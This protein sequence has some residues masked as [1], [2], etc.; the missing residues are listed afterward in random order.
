MHFVFYL[1]DARIDVFQLQGKKNIGHETFDWSKIESYVQK[2]PKNALISLV[3]D[4]VDEDLQVEFMPSLLPWEKVRLQQRLAEKWQQKGALN[5]RFIWTGEKQQNDDGRHEELLLTSVLHP[6]KPL[7]KLLKQLTDRNALLIGVHSAAFMLKSVLEKK[8]VSQLNLSKKQRKTPIMLIVRMTPH[9]YRQCF[10]YHGQLRLSR[11]VELESKDYSEQEIIELLA[12]ESKLATRFIYNQKVLPLGVP[13]N[14][15]LIDHLN[16][17]MIRSYWQEFEQ[18][19]NVISPQWNPEQNFFEVI[20][21]K[22]YPLTTRRKTFFGSDLLAHEL[23][24]GLTPSFFK[25]DHITK[26]NSLRTLATV[27]KIGALSVLVFI[28]FSLVSASLQSNY[29]QKRSE[30]YQQR[31]TYLNAEQDFLLS[32]LQGR[33]QA[34]DMQASVE[35]TDKLNQLNQ[36]RPYGAPLVQIA[37]HLS[38]HPKIKIQTLSWK[39]VAQTD[40]STILVVLNGW[41]SPFEGEYK[42]LTDTLDA[43]E[44]D[45]LSQANITRVNLVQKPFNQDQ[46]QVLNVTPSRN[47]IALPFVM[48]WEMRLTSAG[49]IR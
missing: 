4:M 49:E 14:F 45:L 21:L 32:Q 19:G 47:I 9:H 5:Q 11:L 20:N 7:Q 2:L 26:V 27:L 6:F 1:H 40:D 17:N 29:W 25:F 13:F 42:V 28:L 30:I 36:Q 34:D 44:A 10:F 35:F 8:L 41:V 24:R 15:I 38:H 46:Q 23:H 22:N 43:L 33:V 12:A 18:I 16:E 3:L 48:E 39:P 37:Q 31:I